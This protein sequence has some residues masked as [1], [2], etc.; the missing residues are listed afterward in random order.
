MKSREWLF[1]FFSSLVAVP[2][3]AQPAKNLPTIIT[4]KEANQR[5]QGPEA[6]PIRKIEDD[7]REP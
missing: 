5:D 6:G 2:A 1:G 4:L 3:I 7:R